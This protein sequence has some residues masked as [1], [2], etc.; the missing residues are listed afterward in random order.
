MFSESSLRSAESS[1]AYTEHSWEVF[2][3]SWYFKRKC[4]LRHCRSSISLY[5]HTLSSM[6]ILTTVPTNSSLDQ[7]NFTQVINTWIQNPNKPIHNSDLMVQGYLRPGLFKVQFTARAAPRT[8]CPVEAGKRHVLHQTGD[9]QFT[10]GRAHRTLR[11][12]S[13]DQ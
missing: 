7:N 3:D 8:T 6:T 12:M 1:P 5:P 13:L 9:Q 2:P 4:L 11:S 10:E